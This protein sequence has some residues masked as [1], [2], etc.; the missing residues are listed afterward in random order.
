MP[1]PSQGGDV[2]GSFGELGVARLLGPVQK[3]LEGTLVIP[4]CRC[5]LRTVSGVPNEAG[6]KKGAGIPGRNGPGPG[7]C[8]LSSVIKHLFPPPSHPQGNPARRAHV[9]YRHTLLAQTIP[10][11]LPSTLLGFRKVPILDS[12]IS[13]DSMIGISKRFFA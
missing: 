12:S 6:P 8:L 11:V 1:C 5:A 9:S 7:E 10:A 13:S 4:V 2:V 3:V